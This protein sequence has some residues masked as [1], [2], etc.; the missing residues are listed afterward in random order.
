MTEIG[1]IVTTVDTSTIFCIKLPLGLLKHFS[2]G[3]NL[4]FKSLIDYYYFEIPH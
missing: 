1:L 2:L 3:A 4:K